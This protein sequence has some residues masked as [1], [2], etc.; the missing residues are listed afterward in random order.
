MFFNRRKRYNGDVSALLPAFGIDM[1]E[2]G[3]MSALGILDHAWADKYSVYEAALVLA[4]RQAFALYENKEL[5]RA[6][7]LAQDRLKPIQA[8]WIKK[9]IVQPQRM[10]QFAKR[11]DERM[12]MARSSGRTKQDLIRTLV[13]KRLT[14]DALAEAVGATPEAID[15]LPPEMIM[16]LPEATIVSIVEAWTQGR[17]Q[18][19]PEEKIFQFIEAHRSMGPQ[20]KLHASPTLSSYVRYRIDL[21]CGHAHP[22]FPQRT[23]STVFVRHISFLSIAKK[24]SSNLQL[25]VIRVLGTGRTIAAFA[26]QH[27]KGKG[28]GLES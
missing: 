19:I 4:Y 9:G 3:I 24:V 26:L 7:R 28:S 14:G 15:E 20:G 11:L 27:L 25:P 22:P 10:E 12:V 8:D 5:Q 1:Q 16:G 23:S 18:Q 13:K 6:D 2:I 21:E 17:S